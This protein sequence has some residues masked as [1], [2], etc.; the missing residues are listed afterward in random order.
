[1]S[2]LLFSKIM[3]PQRGGGIIDRP[4]LA[5][6]IARIGGHKA[7]FLTAPAGYGKT[8]AMLQAANASCRTLVWYQLDA[9]DNDPA[10]FLRYLTASIARQFPG[11]GQQ[12]EQVIGGECESRLRL[13][14]T[15]FV[16]ELSRW[17]T[18]PLLLILD[19]YHE[20]IAPFVHR[21]LQDLLIHL[22]GHVHVM[23]ASRTMPPLNLSNLKASGDVGVV[24]TGDLRFTRE[25]LQA[26]LAERGWR[27]SGEAVE[28]LERK[29]EGWPA[30]VKFLAGL[31]FVDA[32]FFHPDGGAVEAYE[33]LAA[34][35]MARQP[36]N[37]ADFLKKSAVLETVTAEDCDLLLARDDSRQMLELLERQNLFLIPLA[38]PGNAYRYHQLFREFLLD[39][40]GAERRRWQREAGIIARNRGDLSTAVEYFRAAG[41]VRDLLNIL[42][43]AA[44]QAFDQGRWQT[45]VRWLAAVAE[46]DLSADPWLGLYR[47]KNEIYQGR[48]DEAEKWLNGAVPLFADSDDQDGLAESRLLQA[49]IL[50]CRGR[51]EESI[52]LLEQVLH[53]LPPAESARVDLPLEKSSCLL[54]TGRFQA[55]EAVLTSALESAKWNNDK[56][57][58]AHLMEGL[59]HVYWMQGDYPKALRMYQKGTERLPEWFMPSYHMQDYIAFIYLDWGEWDRA[60]EYA[61]RNA[62]IKE[63]LGLTDA[64]P[65]T[66]GQLSS[67]YC[68]RGEW[69]LAEEYCKRAIDFVRENNGDRIYSAL[70]LALWA[71]CLGLQDRWIEAREKAVEALT[72]AGPYYVLAENVCQVLGS[73]S[74]I[75]TGELH[76]GKEL[77]SAAIKV[78][79]QAG[80]KRG[81]YYGYAFQAWLS[82]SEG[83][84]ATGREYTEKV[85]ELAA[86]HNLL[87]IF[88]TYYE[89]LRPVLKLGLEKGVEVAFIQRI[90]VRKGDRSVPFLA[91]LAKYDDPQVRLRVIA[92]LAE[93][94]GTHAAAVITSLTTDANA[95]VR[96]SAR[97]AAQRMGMPAADGEGFA[98]LAAVSLQVDMLGS[99]KAFIQGTELGKTGWR[100]TK[101]RDLLAY[102]IHK[103]EPVGRERIQEDLWPEM[104]ME[105]AANIFH[106]TLHRLRKMLNKAGCPDILRYGDKRYVLQLDSFSCD[107]QRFRELVAAGLRKDA[108]PEERVACLEQAAALYRGDYLEEM[109]YLWLLHC[110]E[111]LRRMYADTRMSLARHY[112]EILSYAQAIA[113]LQIVEEADP[114]AEEVHALLMKAYAEQG[115][116]MAAVRQ[117]QKA[118]SILKKELGLRPSMQLYGLYLKLMK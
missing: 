103:G 55:A 102:L 47:A 5:N 26:F 111:R 10:V 69:A 85:L 28:M 86:K 19:D 49:R 9:Y 59:G 35:V 64:L 106:V 75:H 81:Q 8:V 100:T 93:I 88:L 43:E 65:S 25:E 34:E 30:A 27:L 97:L 17:D 20:I 6:V 114:F 96:Q 91:Y 115:S 87:N 80:F 51:F 76:R 62:A 104:N 40:L 70:S 98:K 3:P 110:R 108:S 56:Y 83:D 57:A 107:T 41:A 68:S 95:T 4:R 112:L 99:F 60:L 11:F 67:I 63:N 73:L 61:K 15:A 48:L 12:L 54:Y 22:P 1:M 42:R 77:L 2:D 118:E 105:N 29:V 21:F 18:V 23:I 92:P 94:R 31:K 52:E 101:I 90:F 16:N 33:Y 79:D 58:M 24:K 39:R 82:I 53:Q 7:T 14:L 71:E 117:Y 74:F 38:G 66:Y 72:E 36:D 45:V 109:D 89:M 113:H 116:R 46:E 84:L 13:L 37:V 32:S 78:F 44:R 50:R